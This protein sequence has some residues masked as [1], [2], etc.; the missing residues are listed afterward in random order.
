MARAPSCR[1]KAVKRER[2]QK[3]KLKIQ[4]LKQNMAKIGMDQ[5]RLREEQSHVRQRFT[6]LKMGCDRLR[7]E[8]NLIFKQATITKI[9]LAV[10]FQILKAREDGDFSKAAK[11][12]L[13]L[14][15]VF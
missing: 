11:L 2:V 3:Q 9:R 6:S 5:R 15:S 14:R 8:I 7:E 12:T 10:M 4:S 13:F 1:Q